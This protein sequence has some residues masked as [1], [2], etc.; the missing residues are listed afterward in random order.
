MPCDRDFGHIEKPVRHL[1]VF[2]KEEY[3][4]QV[5]DCRITRPFTVVRMTRELFLDVGV[6]KNY[7]TKHS[8]QSNASFADARVFCFSSEY[9]MAYGIMMM[10]D[11]NET[12]YVK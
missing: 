12:T 9:K 10:Y 4:K 8:L 7:M 1:E 6:L 3:C 2:T 11:Q 5:E